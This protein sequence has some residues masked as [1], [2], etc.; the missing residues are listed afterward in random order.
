MD[1]SD[2][3]KPRKMY[4]ITTVGKKQLEEFQID[5]EEKIKNLSFFLDKYKDWK[6]SNHD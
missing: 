2:Q 4:K 5:I 6:E 1:T 3:D